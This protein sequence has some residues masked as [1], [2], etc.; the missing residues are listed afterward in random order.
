MTLFPEQFE[1]TLCANGM[2][3]RILLEGD[4]IHLATVGG[5]ECPL[6]IETLKSI[7]A[8]IVRRWNTV[9]EP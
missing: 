3:I 9:R 1:Y 5:P 4:W 6:P 7:A 8:E 2:Q